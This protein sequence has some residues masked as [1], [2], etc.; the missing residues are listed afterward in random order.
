MFFQEVLNLECFVW[1]QDSPQ[2]MSW[3]PC[4]L[5]PPCPTLFCT[6]PLDYAAPSTLDCAGCFSPLV[7]DLKGTET[8]TLI[9]IPL[10]R[11]LDSGL[12]SS[13]LL[14]LEDLKR[15]TELRQDS[16][17]SWTAHGILVSSHN[18]IYKTLFF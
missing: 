2:N 15:T 7:W 14:R 18:E 5:S 8:P 1:L 3:P 13:L 16:L 17:W 9:L 12:P 6:C 10:A 11:S 4:L